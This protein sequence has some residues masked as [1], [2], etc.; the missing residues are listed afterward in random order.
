MK[1][2]NQTNN[3]ETKETNFKHKFSTRVFRMHM[4]MDPRETDLQK[5]SYKQNVCLFLPSSCVGI[6]DVILSAKSCSLKALLQSR[7]S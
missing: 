6:E 5:Y 2:I 3:I 1:K 7:K 4:F